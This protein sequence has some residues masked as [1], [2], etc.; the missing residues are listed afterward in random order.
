MSKNTG[1]EILAKEIEA[2]P[3]ALD[4]AR[5]QDENQTVI[6]ARM[7]SGLSEEGW[8][9]AKR[10]YELD[11]WHAFSV[12]GAPQEGMEEVPAA[13]GTYLSISPFREVPGALTR[14]VFTKVLRR[15]IMRLTRNGGSCSLVSAALAD[16]QRLSVALG[17]STVKRLE[18]MLGSILLSQMEACDTLGIM[19]P[20]QFIC[21]LPGFGQLAARH[22]AEKGQLAFM[23]SAR[24]FFPTGGV[25]A[26]QCAEC[27]IGIVN[28]LQGECGRAED[29]LNRART[30][31]EIALGRNEGHIHQETT[32]SPLENTTLVQSSEKRFLFFG[33]DEA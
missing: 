12:A 15:E 7:V 19:R 29:L 33:G 1:P 20:G 21:A 2:M 26:G 13:A 24:P 31:L 6:L 18:G 32:G 28:I 8:R 4:A 22:F 16:R 30:T 25:S 14:G 11:Q 5:G 10:N 23:E 17:E 9:E 27:A 3:K